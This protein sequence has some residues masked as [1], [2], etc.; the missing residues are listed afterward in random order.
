MSE[1]GEP[2]IKYFKS[3]FETQRH[4]HNLSGLLN[5]DWLD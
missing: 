3:P 4:K 5:L 1:E 2:D